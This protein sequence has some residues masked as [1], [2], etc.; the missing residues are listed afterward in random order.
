MALNRFTNLE[1]KLNG[2]TSLRKAYDQFMLEYENL[3]HMIKIN[4]PE[5]AD[6]SYY[7]PHHCVQK[8][9]SLTTKH[10]VVFDA[11]ASTSSGYSINDLQMIGPV[12]QADLFSIFIRFR[13]HKIAVTADVSKM[14]RQ[15][16][17]DPSQRSLQRILW[18]DGAD[19]DVSVYELNT[20]TYGT[21]AASYLAI[22]SLLQTAFENENLQEASLRIKRDF[23]VD[24]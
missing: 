16:L 6:Y 15:I 13:Q 23:Y 12:I 10:R 21:A 4:K 1:R 7:M 17:I 24:D 2:D 22:R 11:S 5:E 18:R 19:K 3:G 8:A 9:D 14:Y 20:V